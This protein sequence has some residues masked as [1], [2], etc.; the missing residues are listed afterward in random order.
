[1][2]G[3]YAMPLNDDTG[4][5]GVL[6]LESS[7]PDFLGAAH[8]EILEV[9]AGQATEALRNA[10]FTSIIVPGAGEPNFD[11][12]EVNPYETTKQRQEAEDDPEY[13]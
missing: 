2:R 1:M 6:A 10:G 8:I 9:L 12:L 13:P 5:V 7:D 11:A 4:R 3:F